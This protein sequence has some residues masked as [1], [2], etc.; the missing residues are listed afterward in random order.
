MDA[1]WARRDP[2]R[3]GTCCPTHRLVDTLPYLCLS[4]G[5]LAGR[6]FAEVARVL[7]ASADLVILNFSYRDAVAA[8]R[9]DLERLILPLGLTL[10]ARSSILALPGTHPHF[11]LS[12]AGLHPPAHNETQITVLPTARGACDSMISGLRTRSLAK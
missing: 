11:I 1:G 3:T 6:Y 8:D 5:E 4:E 12:R 10:V 7:H 2:I 9:R